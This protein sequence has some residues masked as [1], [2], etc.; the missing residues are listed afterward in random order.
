MARPGH[1][2]ADRGAAR[3]LRR[4]ARRRPGHHFEVAAGIEPYLRADGTK[5][6][7]LML[8]ERQMRPEA[9]S[10]RRGGYI[11]RR[12]TAAGAPELSMLPELDH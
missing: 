2:P 1:G 3:P 8:L 5:V 11:D 9:Y 4:A 6:W 7:S 12:R 10:R